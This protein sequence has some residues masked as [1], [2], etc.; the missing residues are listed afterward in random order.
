[1]RAHSSFIARVALRPIRPGAL[2]ALGFL[3]PL[4][5]GLQAQSTPTGALIRGRVV[6][7]LGRPIANADAAL[8]G[9][10]YRSTSSTAGAFVLRDV[11]EGQYRLVVRHVGFE[12]VYLA[13][14]IAGPDTIDADVV[15]K[16][17]TSTLDSIVVTADRTD[18][19]D[20]EAN[21]KLG[22]G[23]FF[24]R[25][26]IV[27]H[28]GSVLHTLLRTKLSGFSYPERPCG[29]VALATGGTR[30]GASL[31][32]VSVVGKGVCPM[33]DLCYAQL[34]VDGQRVFGTDHATAP[35]NIDEYRLDQLEAI[36][37]YASASTTPARY[38]ALGAVCGTVALWRRR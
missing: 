37:V 19:S 36:E 31:N 13:A 38:N 7:S 15:L 3:L 23:T 1:M 35:P 16:H 9:T 6:D 27:Q 11:A 33:P 5:G 24:A 28:A 22:F 8:L 25:E 10:P 29:G 32:G 17:A 12:P 18:L 4:M 21:R 34:F 14:N 30:A 2:I 26:D 20:F